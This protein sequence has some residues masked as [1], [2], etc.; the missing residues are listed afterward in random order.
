MSK[1]M[2]IA[3]G[4]LAALAALGIALFWFMSNAERENPAAE[5]YQNGKLIRT[6]SLLE[7]T[8]FTVYCDGGFNVVTVS[9]GKIYV[10]SADCPDKVCVKQGKISGAVPI[11]C[12]PHKLEIRV[13]NGDKTVDA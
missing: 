7:N 12:L 1:K 3:A 4:V 11:V 10:S 8:E 9:D 6:V 2:I 5:I 13:V